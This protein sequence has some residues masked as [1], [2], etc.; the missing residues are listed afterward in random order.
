MYEHNDDWNKSQHVE[1]VE[2][3]QNLS[4]EEDDEPSAGSS[5]LITVQVSIENGNPP[6]AP[7]STGIHAMVNFLLSFK[8]GIHRLMG[9]SFM[10]D[11]FV[12]IALSPALVTCKY[13]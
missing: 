1:D 3:D 13:I 6:A 11:H 12:S 8:H 5:K 2:D 4:E 10:V 9:V 7:K